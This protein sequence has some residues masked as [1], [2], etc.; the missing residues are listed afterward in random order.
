MQALG[1]LAP[2]RHRVRVALAGLALAAAV[3]VVDR[4]HRQAAHRRADAAPA[5]GAG[6]AVVPQVVLF[7]ADFADGRA[8]LGRDLADLAGAQADR[9]VLAFAR[10]QLHR[11]AGGARQLRALARA[12]LDAMDVGAG[13]DVAQRQRVARLDVGVG[14]RDHGV[15]RLQALRRDDV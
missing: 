8:A 1:L 3:R 14:A 7:V 15:A 11:G 2:R 6:L 13:R 4:V 5:L 9:D 12:H 10:D